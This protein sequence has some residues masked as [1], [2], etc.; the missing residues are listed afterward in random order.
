MPGTYKLGRPI[1]RFQSFQLSLAASLGQNSG[2]KNA[3]FCQWGLRR[4]RV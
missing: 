4:A 3:P 1:E 2:R